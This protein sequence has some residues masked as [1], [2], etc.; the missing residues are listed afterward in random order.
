MT[1]Q[2][3]RQ[4]LEESLDDQIGFLT[5]QWLTALMKQGRAE[6]KII[7]LKKEIQRFR[8]GWN[9]FYK[10]KEDTTEQDATIRALE[11]T[12]EVLRKELVI[13]GKPLSEYEP[14]WQSIQANVATFSVR[15]H[16]N[17]TWGIWRQGEFGGVWSIDVKQEYPTKMDAEDALDRHI[18]FHPNWKRC[19]PLIKAKESSDETV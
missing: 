19:D 14:R 13:A 9:D 4:E 15:Q 17:E 6:D 5:R 12:I 1:K 7:E 8:D 2:T 16:E 11:E 10:R 18:N 3:Q